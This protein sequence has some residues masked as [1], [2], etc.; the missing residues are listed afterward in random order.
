M[1]GR[2]LVA[3]IL[4]RIENSNGQEAPDDPLDSI[5]A[6]VDR[7]LLQHRQRSQDP[8]WIV[9]GLNRRHQDFQ[10]SPWIDRIARV[11]NDL[12]ARR[13]AA[14]VTVSGRQLRAVAR[15]E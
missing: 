9:G 2:V 15:R 8:Q 14:D 11:V 1:H 6:E 10:F 13:R 3:G 4:D 5:G 7:H 12:L